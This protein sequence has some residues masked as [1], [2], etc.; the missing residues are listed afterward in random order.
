MRA[1]QVPRL[2]REKVISLGLTLA[3]TALG[4]G[5][6]W[7]YSTV[8]SWLSDGLTYSGG[9][10]FLAVAAW[11]VGDWVRKRLP[12]R[13]W[14]PD[15]PWQVARWL[16]QRPTVSPISIVPAIR[17]DIDRME[18]CT[19]VL[20]LNHWIARA[21]SDVSV[22]YEAAV[23]TVEQSIQGRRRRFTFRPLDVGGL[24]A[25][26]IRHSDRNRAFQCSFVWT[27][28]PARI[29]RAPDL[30]AK[31]GWTLSGIR[32]VVHSDPNLTGRLPTI[33]QQQLS[34]ADLAALSKEVTVLQGSAFPS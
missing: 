12:A 32:A 26:P 24:L 16:L 33:R 15:R 11:I 29:D 5:L 18:E 31:F 8:P 22:L 7:K 34:A 14:F 13:P 28:L 3:I 1:T 10:L 19:L 20:T 30:R 2:T 9:L 25:H 21:P 4:L 6:P 27:G 17:W 23:L